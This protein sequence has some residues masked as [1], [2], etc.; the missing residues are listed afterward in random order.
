M[1]LKYEKEMM[2][3]YDERAGEY[4]EIYIGKGPASLKKDSYFKDVEEVSKLL[5]GFGKGKIIDIGCG[6][7]FWFPKYAKRYSDFTFLDQSKK[8]LEECKKRVESLG[9]LNKSKFVQGNVLNV[10]LERY[11]S[12]LAGFL[13]SHFTKEQELIFFKHLSSILIKDGTFVII[14]SAWNKERE[15]VRKKEEIQYRKL[16]DGRIFKV[17][18]KYFK[19]EDIKK[20]SS[21]YKFVIKD[22]YFGEVFLAFIAGFSKG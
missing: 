14:D 4:D 17:Y 2:D 8:M 11:D 10:K 9:Y 13:V 3:Y 22:I 15:K 12:A 18:K 1:E 6:T 5:T 20:M 19:V 7:G 16:N 21:R